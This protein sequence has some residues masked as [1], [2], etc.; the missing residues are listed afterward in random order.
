VLAISSKGELAV[1][2]NVQVVGW[3]T[4]VGTLARVPLGG[5]GPRALLDG[6]SYADWSPDG[7]E[8]AI[9]TTSG[10]RDRLEY[11]IGTVLYE[12]SGAL[13]SAR[14][15]PRG[16][17]VALFEHPSH[18]DDRGFVITVDRSGKRRMLTGVYASLEGLAWSPAGDEVLFTGSSLDG[19]GSYE[20]YGVDLAGRTR[21]MAR[22][23]GGF[24]LHGIWRTGR[25][26]V[27]RDDR[28]IGIR[29][30]GPDGQ[31][32]RD[33]SF[34]DGSWNPILSS[35]GRTLLFTEISAPIGA[36]YTFYM[37][38]TDGSPV[39]R[40]GEGMAQDLSPDGKWALA[41]MQA[42][43][44]VV[45]YSTGSGER[46]ALERGSL[47]GHRYASWFPDGKRILVCGNEQGKA[48]RCYA[49]AVAGGTP[50]AVTPGGEK[51]LVS[52]DGQRVVVWS[53]ESAPA[54]YR[55]DGSGPEAIP[56]ASTA[57]MPIRWSPDGRSLLVLHSGYRQ[58]QGSI[59]RV[60]LLSGKREVVREFA[61]PERAGELFVSSASVAPDLKSYAYNFF[62][63]RSILF[64]VEGAR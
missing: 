42:P 11:P 40:L 37:R 47:V 52:Q 32:E 30:R 46:R 5:T 18:F 60:D 50:R 33:L 64:L 10:G 22:S 20:A 4:C 9:I 6:V 19:Y 53:A 25:W 7:A 63:M 2:T 36:N 31:A 62:R 59:E 8:L 48:A 26:L 27:T 38:G 41:I 16:D 55:L 3:R 61:P 44:Q 34:L 28:A 15:S 12:S 43:Q 51:G 14:V 49:Q 29:G 23:A 17:Q 1:L 57:D 56:S 35:D 54:I 58:A 24:T 45:I 13:S 39:V 21:V